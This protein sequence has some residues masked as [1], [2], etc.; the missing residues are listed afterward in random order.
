MLDFFIEDRYMF[1][2]S[3]RI[4]VKAGDGGD[5]AVSFHRAKY[6]PKGGPDGGNGGRGGSVYIRA[7]KDLNT[8]QNFRDRKKYVA[9]DGEDG[10]K[11]KQAGKA[12]EDL[13]IEVPVGTVVREFSSQKLLADLVEDGQ[14]MLLTAGGRGGV[15]NA[16][17]KSSKR[18]T[19]D[20]ARPGETKE[21]FYLSLELKLLADVGLIGMPNVGKSTFLS[22]VTAAKPKIANYHFTTLEPNLGI[23]TVDDGLY[24]FTI[25]DIPGLIEGASEGTGLGDEFLK[26]IERTRLLVHFLDASGIEGRDPYQDFLDIN[27]ELEEFNPK[28]AEKEQIVALN[29]IDLMDKEDAEALKQ[30][31]EDLGYET[32]LLSAPIEYGTKDLLNAIAR[33][34]PTIEKEPLYEET[35]SRKVYSLDDLEKTYSIE[36][37]DNNTYKV[38][39]DWIDDLLRQI[40]FNSMESFNFFQKKLKEKGIISE[41]KDLGIEEGDT[42]IV[43]DLQFDYYE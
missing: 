32:Y 30:K 28:L 16:A 12:G 35:E 6:I 14:S 29:K 38:S 2:D 11:Q 4:F 40:N 8:L 17:F 41:L 25:A 37:V 33:K 15:G 24:S 9:E 13:I 31:F 39:G 7:T 36:K 42:V 21:G 22:V 43:D 19:P 20:F 23:A 18:Q 10:A 34:L 27:K 3:A 26:H 1:V 5:G